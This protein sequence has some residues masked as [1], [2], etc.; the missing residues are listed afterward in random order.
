MDWKKNLTP[1]KRPARWVDDLEEAIFFL[2][3]VGV[4][5][6]KTSGGEEVDIEAASE[7]Q[8]KQVLNQLNVRIRAKEVAI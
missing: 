8:I 5:H 2:K 4:D 1:K 6:F 3:Q 7:K